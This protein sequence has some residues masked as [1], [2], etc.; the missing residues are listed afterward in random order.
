MK[1]LLLSAVIAVLAMN[2]VN[3]QEVKFGAKAGVNFASLSGD[4][5]E[6]LDGRTSFHIGGVANIAI[7]EKFAIQPELVYSSQGFTVSESGVDVTGKLDYINLPIL[8]DFSVAE[9]FSIQAGPQIGFN[10]TDKVEAEGESESLDAESID[11]G[12]AFG[13][14]YKMETGLFFQARYVLGFSEII[15]D[16]DAK[17]NVLSLSVGYFF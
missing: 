1:K 2:N 13:V 5:V 8:A 15:E 9:G 10:I 3:A 11:L 6:D 4:D 7:S 14:Q 16:V 12:A 17:N